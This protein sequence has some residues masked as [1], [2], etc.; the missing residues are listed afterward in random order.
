MWV[1]DQGAHLGIR[2]SGWSVCESCLWGVCLTASASSRCCVG[3]AQGTPITDGGGLTV[4]GGD[5]P[6]AQL[7]QNGL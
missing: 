4:A 1:T 7:V 6:R 2:T 5:Q 3:S